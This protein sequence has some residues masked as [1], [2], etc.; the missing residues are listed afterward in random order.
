MPAD[1]LVIFGC[2]GKQYYTCSVGEAYKINHGQY[3]NFETISYRFKYVFN[4]IMCVMQMTG[5]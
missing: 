3:E 1:A 4:E 2:R 5:L